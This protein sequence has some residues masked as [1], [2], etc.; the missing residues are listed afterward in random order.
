MD[1]PSAQTSRK[2]PLRIRA[3][4]ASAACAALLAGGA[5]TL[6]GRDAYAAE[7]NLVRNA[8]F[9]SGL[10]G[11]TCSAGSGTTVSSPVHGGTAA[12]KA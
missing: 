10:N 7:P 11:W 2:R 1:R 3:G 6:D 8:G 12:L 4:V 9:E 5:T